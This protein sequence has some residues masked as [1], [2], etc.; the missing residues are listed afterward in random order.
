M[1]LQVDLLVLRARHSS[2]MGLLPIVEECLAR[3][4]MIYPQTHS[5]HLIFVVEG[6]D[7]VSACFNNCVCFQVWEVKAA[8]LSIS[9]VYTAAAGIVRTPTRPHSLSLSLSLSLSS[10]DLYCYEYVYVLL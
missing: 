5:L 7:C 1:P 2:T 10:L 8:D 3:E 9:P 4:T 6:D